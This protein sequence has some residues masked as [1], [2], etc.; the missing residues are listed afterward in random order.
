MCTDLYFN[1]GR[2]SSGSMGIVPCVALLNDS[3]RND[4]ESHAAVAARNV[5]RK[6][7][8]EQNPEG[9]D[10]RNDAQD[11]AAGKKISVNPINLCH[12]QY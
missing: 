7:N 8:S 11:T 6:L 1:I 4:Q 5:F 2:L 3:N 10:A 12:L 9:C